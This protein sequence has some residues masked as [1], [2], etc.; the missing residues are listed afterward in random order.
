[1]MFCMEK[2]T[3]TSLR[4]KLYQVIDRVIKT[5][6]PQEIERDGHKLKIILADE[7]KDKLSNLKKHNSIIGNPDDL[8][9]IKVGK[10]SEEDKI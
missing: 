7:K 1:M 4:D 10:W 8:I 2:M 5:G 6:I 9:N 3:V